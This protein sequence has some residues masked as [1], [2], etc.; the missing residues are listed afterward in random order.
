MNRLQTLC[1]LVVLALACL[2]LPGCELTDENLEF[3]NGDLGYYLQVGEHSY[4][5]V[6][7]LEKLPPIAFAGRSRCSPDPA[8][9]Y[10]SRSTT[11]RAWS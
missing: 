11:A 9:E 7:I 2:C 1:S 5:F 6:I 8:I 3:K 10:S 4:M